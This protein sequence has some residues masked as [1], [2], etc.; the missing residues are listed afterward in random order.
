MARKSSNYYLNVINR[1]QTYLERLKAGYFKS[2]DQEIKN[3]DKAIVE[4]LNALRVDS[5]KEITQTRFNE[6]LRE[7]R[8]MQLSLYS[9]QTAK[10]LK[11]L[12]ELSGEE[13]LFE[14]E[15][16]VQTVVA[17]KGQKIFKAVEPWNAVNKNPIQS[18]GDLLAPFVKDLSARQ[19]SRVEKAIITG[20]AQGR[21]ISQIVQSIRGTKARGYKDGVLKT[22][23][24]DCRTVVRTAV[25]HCSTQARVATWEANSHLI[26]GY[27]WI[28]TLDGETSPQCRNLDLQVFQIGSGPLP[29][30]HPGCRSTTAPYFKDDVELWDKG[31]TRSSANG[32]IPANTSYYQW[33]KTQPSAFQNDAIG[34]TRGKLLRDGGL[35]AK[36]FGDLQLDRNFQPLTLDEMKKLKPNAFDKANI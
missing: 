21:T 25:Q 17:K 1:H 11:N 36:E 6:L 19:I 5:L 13:A 7:L 3:A 14:K 31:A 30:I 4:I 20:R 10:L 9:G 12:E 16:L 27:Q 22:N 18:S 29:P 23:W 8:V 28:S 35:S 32:P 33:L 24:N 15:L 2:F 34:P 26:D